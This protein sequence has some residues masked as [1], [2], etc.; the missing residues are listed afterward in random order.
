VRE[1][2][3][4]VEAGMTPLQALQ[5]GTTQTAKMLGMEADVGR[6]KAGHYADIVALDAD[7]TKDI[8]ALRTIGF[9]MKGGA[10]VRNDGSQR[11]L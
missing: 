2:E 9:V 5:A 7:P 4:Y 3:L 10:V 8:R 6:I 11:A 1:A